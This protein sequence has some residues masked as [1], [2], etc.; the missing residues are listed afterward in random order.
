MN[1]SSHN[2][3]QSGPWSQNGRPPVPQ[4]FLDDAKRIIEAEKA[5]GEVRTFCGVPLTELTREECLAALVLHLH[6]DQY[7]IKG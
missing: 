4:G 5:S 6:W 7:R 1:D 3:A 2:G